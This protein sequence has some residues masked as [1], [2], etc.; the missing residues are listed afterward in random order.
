MTMLRGT[1]RLLTMSSTLTLRQFSLDSF[2]LDHLAM[3]AGAV[4]VCP[5]LF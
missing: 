4:S 3:F 1:A 5:Q 2:G